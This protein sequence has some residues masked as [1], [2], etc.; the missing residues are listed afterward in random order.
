MT[1]SSKSHLLPSKIT[2]SG[3]SFERRTLESISSFHYIDD[4]MD[5]RGSGRKEGGKERKGERYGLV[6]IKDIREGVSAYLGNS[7][8]GLRST[9]VIDKHGSDSILIVDSGNR[10]KAILT[11]NIPQL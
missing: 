11:G 3:A 6:S 9:D 4:G 10:T 1:A 5:E 2:G 8:K 7:L